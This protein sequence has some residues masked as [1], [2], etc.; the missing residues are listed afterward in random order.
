V[1]VKLGGFTPLIDR[2]SSLGGATPYE[3][4][5]GTSPM[6]LFDFSGE[7]QFFQAFGTAG[8][9]VSVGYAEKYAPARL[10]DGTATAESTGLRLFPLQLFGVYRF[11][12]AAHTWG[13]PLVPYVKAGLNCTIWSSTKGADLETTSSGQK[14]M[15]ARFGWGFTGGLSLLLDVFE[16]RMARDFDTDLGVNHSYLF[17]EYNF[18][19]V[20][21]FYTPGLDLSGRYLMFGA[22]FEM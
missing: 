21:N 15:G 20:N 10:A 1:E 2:E 18:A 7:R 13:V 17:V 22:A 14:A 12:Y 8:A 6:L 16:P 4:T 5:Y 19:D 11:D 9:G 3:D